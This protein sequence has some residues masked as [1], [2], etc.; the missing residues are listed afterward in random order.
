MCMSFSQC[1]ALP[2]S[3][4]H[5]ARQALVLQLHPHAYQRHGRD[6]GSRM[7]LRTAI[8]GVCMALYLSMAIAVLPRPMACQDCSAEWCMH[9]M[10]RLSQ[11][12]FLMISRQRM[13][14][15][16][17]LQNLPHARTPRESPL[18]GEHCV[19]LVGPAVELVPWPRRLIE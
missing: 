9:G 6:S 18:L 17:S 2:H 13:N 1:L 7:P 5:I 12:S 14:T 4:S 15:L 10:R 11:H 19:W 8:C 16:Q 3:A